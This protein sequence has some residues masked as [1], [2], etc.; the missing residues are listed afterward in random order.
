MARPATHPDSEKPN[1]D[2][3]SNPLAA[4]VRLLA[5]QAAAEAMRHGAIDKAVSW[6]KPDTSK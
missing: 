1:T 5:R 3:E 4:L 6:Q 2:P